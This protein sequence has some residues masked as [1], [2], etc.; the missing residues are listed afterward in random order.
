MNFGKKTKQNLLNS[1]RSSSPSYV[2]IKSLVLTSLDYLFNSMKR[3]MGIKYGCTDSVMISFTG[4]GLEGI[5]QLK[6]S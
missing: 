4:Y 2:N 5:Y 1:P 6:D 3:R